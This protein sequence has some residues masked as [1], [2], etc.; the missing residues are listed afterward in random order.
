VNKKVKRT[1]SIEISVEREEFLLIRRPVSRTT[2]WCAECGENVPMLRLEDATA[3]T[4]ASWQAVLRRV[5]AR[6]VH[7]T[8]TPDG[9]LFIC[10][11]SL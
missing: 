6:D 2:L 8:E 1:R 5:E 9:I 3:V 7:S 4:G 10:I 11:K